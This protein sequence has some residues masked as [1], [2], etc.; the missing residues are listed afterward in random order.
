MEWMTSRKSWSSNIQVCAVWINTVTVPVSRST[1]PRA[2]ARFT[3]GALRF[4]GS[5]IVVPV[6]AAASSAPAVQL[7]LSRAADG[8]N[9]TSPAA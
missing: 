4:A 9:E 8:K 1:R 2:F 5:S 3:S 6:C 7:P